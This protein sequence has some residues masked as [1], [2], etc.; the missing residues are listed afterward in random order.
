MTEFER[1]RAG[2]YANTM[3][4]SIL[5]PMARDRPKICVNLHQGVE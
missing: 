1:L 3:D 2:H 4:L 5:K